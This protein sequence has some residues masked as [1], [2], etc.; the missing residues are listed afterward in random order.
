MEDRLKS[1]LVIA[2][3]EDPNQISLSRKLTAIK[4]YHQLKSSILHRYLKLESLED[5]KKWSMKRNQLIH[6]L[7]SRQHHDEI[8]KDLAIEGYVLTREVSKA[9]RNFKNYVENNKRP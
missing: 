7:A 2:K 5:I 8:I 1:L 6:A 4:N 9:S 3:K